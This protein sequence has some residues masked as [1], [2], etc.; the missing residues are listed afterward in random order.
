ME[1]LLQSGGV[2]ISAWLNPIWFLLVGLV[3][4]WPGY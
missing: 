1:A 4:G 3:A 2:F